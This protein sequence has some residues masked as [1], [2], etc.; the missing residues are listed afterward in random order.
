VAHDLPRA[1]RELDVVGVDD[2]GRL[3]ST[4]STPTCPRAEARRRLARLQRARHDQPGREIVRRAT[5]RRARARRRLA[6][7]RRSVDLAAIDADFYAWTG[8]K[9]YGPTGIGSP[10]REA[11]A[12]RRDAA[13]IGGGT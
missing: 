5:R 6:G 7:V 8:H 3:S 9:A 2:D 11:R 1:R 12:A 10:A 13:W 4:S